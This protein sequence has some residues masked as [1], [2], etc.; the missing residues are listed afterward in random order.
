MNKFLSV[1]FSMK[2]MLILIIVL[3]SS[4]A[5]GTFIENNYNTLTAKAMIYSSSWIAV[6]MGLL[7]CSLLYNLFTRKLYKKSKISIGLFHVS[8]VVK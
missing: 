1:L 8:F 4:L 3:A 2:L 5:V 6:L 7:C